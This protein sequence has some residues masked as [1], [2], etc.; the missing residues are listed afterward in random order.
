MLSG[1]QDLNLRPLGPESAPVAFAPTYAHQHQV[2]NRPDSFG[3]FSS[4]FRTGSQPNHPFSE[5]LSPF[6]PL[7]SAQLKRAKKGLLSMTAVANLLGVC[8]A[9]AYRLV[10]S[11]SLPHVRI[12]NAIRVDAR[13]LQRWM[14]A[15]KTKGA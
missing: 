8:R 13:D 4:P 3:S 5:I 6:C 11:G 7:T 10:E 14:E 1:R 2:L 12:R 9:T 15:S